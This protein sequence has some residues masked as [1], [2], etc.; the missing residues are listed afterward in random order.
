MPQSK[1]MKKK[2]VKVMKLKE[3][4]KENFTKNMILKDKS[5]CVLG[6]KNCEAKSKI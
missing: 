5:P 4:N 6:Q 3:K 2:F 1:E